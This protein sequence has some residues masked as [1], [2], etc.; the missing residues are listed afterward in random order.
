MKIT[1]N[2]VFAAN[3]YVSELKLKDFDKD[4]RIAL[5]KNLG[6]L[7]QMVKGMQ[8]K[9]E[10][11]RKEVF[12]GL[13]EQQEK[14]IRLR[15]EYN[16]KETTQDRKEEILVELQAFMDYFKAEKEY[17]EV[18]RKFGDDYVDVNIVKFDFDTFVECLVDADIDFTTRS[19]RSV[20]FMFNDFKKN[21]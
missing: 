5:F 19:L 12:K 9:L 15:N 1:N 14:V 4:I 20:W 16:K 13:E 8:E 18:V 11:S 10:A 21:L 7:S 6:E 17:D 2:E 3:N